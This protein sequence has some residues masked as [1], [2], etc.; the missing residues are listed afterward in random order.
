MYYGLIGGKKELENIARKVCDILGYGKNN[1]ADKLLLETSGAETHF[2]TYKDP[3]T[4]AGMGIT[5][6]D[7][8]PFYDIRDRKSKTII[9]GRK[10][11][12][13][14]LDIDIS[15][16]KWEDLRYNPLLSF[17]F[18]RLKYKLVP[19]IIP[20]DLKG[21]AR[22]WKDHYNSKAGDGNIEHY[23]SVNRD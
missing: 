6:F 19:E 5:Q 7:K 10:L 18:T 12:I 1:V 11:L 17:I 4:F 21:R 16:V 23:L 20:A 22:Y 3:T 2:G 14:N 15:L 8:L 9:E 13:Q